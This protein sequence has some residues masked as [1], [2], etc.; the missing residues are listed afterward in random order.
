MD[1]SVDNLMIGSEEAA[2][3]VCPQNRAYGSVHGSSR[4]SYPMMKLKPM[5]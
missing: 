1:G 2:A 4:K 5:R 3:S